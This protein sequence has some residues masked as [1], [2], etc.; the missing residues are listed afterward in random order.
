MSA[1]GGTIELSRCEACFARFLPTD[2]PCPRCGATRIVPYAAPG[3]GRVV[4][5]TELHVP[6]PGVRSPHRLAIVEVADAVRLLASI[7]GPLPIRG[8][9]VGVRKDGDVYRARAE[10]TPE[11]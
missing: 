7:D 1:G 3:V 5:S 9:L 11:V 8:D 6:P 2:G 10:P 4:A